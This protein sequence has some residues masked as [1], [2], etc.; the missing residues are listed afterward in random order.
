MARKRLAIISLT[1]V[2][3][4]LVDLLFRKS[5]SLRLMQAI[6]SFPIIFL[7]GQE[8]FKKSWSQAKQKSMNM[9]TLI[10]I[11]AGSAFVVSIPSI[12]NSDRH[13]YFNAATAIIEF[14][15]IGRYLEE[16]AKNKMIEEVGDLVKMHPHYATLLQDEEEIQITTDK[17]NIDEV[18]LIRS[19]ERIPVDGIVLSGL[20]SVNESMITGNNMPN[21]KEKGHKL[22]DG[23]INGSGV[24]RMK[25]TAVGKD[26][27]LAGLVQM[28][29][30]TQNSKLQVQRT[31]DNISSR[32][33]PAI[34]FLSSITFLG[35]I[36]RGERIA[37]AFGYAVSV[38]LISCPCA[39]GLATPAAT[40]VSSR[41]AARRGI[42][43]RN[44]N[45]PEIMAKIDTIIFDKTGTL[46]ESNAK[47]SDFIN[48]SDLKD[49]YLL[50]LAASVEFNSE[51]LLAKAIVE[52]AKSKG[53]SIKQSSKFYSVPDQGVHSQV[54]K[55]EVVLGNKHWL[56][57]Q[58]IDSTELQEAAEKLSLQGKTLIYLAVD[59]K[60]LALFALSIQLRKDTKQ[61]I[62]SLH[63][64]GIETLMLTGDTEESARPIAELAGIE[65]IK[66][67]ASP[68]EKIQFVK[69]LQ[70]Q[71]KLVA[72]IGD[73]INDAPALAAADVSLVVGNAIGIANE[74][75][76]LFFVDGDI[77][78]V[79][80][81]LVISK[82]TLTVIKQNL[83]W[84]FSYNAIAIPVAMSGK[85]NPIIASAA[86]ALS[87][88]SVIANSLR[89]G[90]K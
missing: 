74:A 65:S 13:A 32:L 22:F 31:A 53:L 33:V 77:A 50:E 16:L 18:L 20:S 42:Y 48:I 52:Y 72:M 14:V 19:G 59:N 17:I 67:Q 15:M 43:I 23:S 84:A 70:S 88:I 8:F 24:L 54:D 28:I 35:W 36:A 9:D 80:E 7:G 78:K 29:D 40:I 71:G 21:I 73:G 45:A 61:V 87:S 75:A 57:G 89:I 69:D 41:Q 26:T 51:H 44:G 58:E 2:P 11:G 63:K 76:D 37:H 85:L 90:E 56:D 27:V 55:H 82:H 47:V 38:L 4:M 6:I 30:Q 3:V 25:T 79:T 83:F 81:M 68:A 39:L 46:T 12:F 1:S 34:V 10:S 64:Q 62:D 60:A 86:M 5:K 66:V 49:D